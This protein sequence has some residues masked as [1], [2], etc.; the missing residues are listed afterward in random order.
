MSTS[1]VLKIKGK[2]ISKGLLLA[3]AVNLLG[4]IWSV[5]GSLIAFPIALL[6]TALT[7]G[8]ATIVYFATARWR[9]ATDGDPSEPALSASADS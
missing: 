8:V 7:L 4:V 5:T 2:A 9:R 1:A 3:L 6:W